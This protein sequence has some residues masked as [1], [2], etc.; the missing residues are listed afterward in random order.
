M[1][2]PHIVEGRVSTP[3]EGRPP[4]VWDPQAAIAAPLCLYQPKVEARW[5]DYNGHLSESCYL[6][7]F[8]DNSDALF[9][10][11]G[12]DEGYRAAGQSFY[13]AETHI[14]Y[15]RE[16]REGEPLRL[17]LQLLDLDAKRMHLMHAMFHAENGTLLATAEQMLLHVDMQA[18]RA[19]PIPQPIYQRLQAIRA[20]HASLPVPPQ[21]GHRIGIVRKAP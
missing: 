15:L 20:A 10:F 8:G 1:T 6:L 3:L 11:I 19:A 16:A 21:A 7:V 4:A 17:T 12:I 9:R 13:T 18:G 5:V 2:D 14:H